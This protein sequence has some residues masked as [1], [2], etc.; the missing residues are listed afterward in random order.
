[1]EAGSFPIAPR[2]RSLEKRSADFLDKSGEV[3]FYEAQFS[4]PWAS[5]R[6]VLQ[7]TTQLWQSGL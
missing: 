1:M 2:P 5:S 7:H 3:F 6:A 4:L